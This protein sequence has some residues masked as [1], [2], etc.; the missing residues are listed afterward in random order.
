MLNLNVG[1][2]ILLKDLLYEALHSTETEPDKISQAKTAVQDVGVHKL[3]LDEAEL[4]LSLR[5]NLV[6]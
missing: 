3:T 2:A 5:T 1:S 4:V 6:T